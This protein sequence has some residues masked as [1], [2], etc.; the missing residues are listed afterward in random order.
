MGKTYKK[1]RPTKAKKK[2]SRSEKR[3]KKYNK[4]TY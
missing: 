2:P 3:E 4:I 1:Q